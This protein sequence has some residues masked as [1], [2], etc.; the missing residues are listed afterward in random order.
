ML[1]PARLA[2]AAAGLTLRD[3]HDCYEWTFPL[4]RTH[5]GML[6]GNAV[7]GAM[8]WGRQN[9]LCITLNRGDFWD[10]RN[11]KAWSAQMSYANIR[12]LLERQD[13]SALREMFATPAKA[14]KPVQRPTLLPLG[15]LELHFEAGCTLH[16]GVLDIGKGE[17]EIIL[18]DDAGTEHAIHLT[19]QMNAPVMAARLPAALARP[20]LRRVTAH[21]VCGEQLAAVDVPQALPFDRDGS[22][23]WVQPRVEEP[24]ACLAYRWKGD[25]LWTTVVYGDAPETAIEAACNALSAGIA[26]GWAALLES[27]A[28]WWTAYWAD[29]P[30]LSIPNEKLSF[31]YNYGMYK[32]AGLTNPAG[33]PAGLQG[34]WI[35]EYQLPPWSGDYHFNINV[36]MCYWPAYAGNRLSHLAPLFR[37][38]ESWL[39]ILRQ[40]ALLFVGVEDG[41]VLPHAVDDRCAIMGGFWT[42]TIDHGCTAWVAKMLYDFWLYGGAGDDFLRAVAFPFMRGAM[43]VYEKMLDERDGTYVL[44]VSVSPEYR[45]AAMNAWGANASFQLAAVHWLLEKLHDAAARLDIT[46]EPQWAKIQRELPRATVQTVGRQERIALWEGTPQEESHRHH[47]HMAGIYPFDTLDIADARWGAIFQTTVNHWIQEGMG[48][49]SGWCMPWAAMLH[50]RAGNRDMAELTLEIWQRVFT[51]EGHGTLHDCEFPGLTLLGA[52]P[53]DR[54]KKEIMQMDAGMGATAAILDLMAHTRRGVLHLFPGCPDHWRDA[55]FDG[56]RIEG[57][58]RI[59]AARRGG[60]VKDLKVVPERDW[61]LKLQNPWPGAATVLRG[62]GVREPASGEVLEIR[63][64]AGETIAI[65]DANA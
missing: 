3:M 51:N 58:M 23:G 42:G 11:G 29:V 6:L 22:A 55:A 4:P 43:R 17:I 24:P 26:A 32:F 2:S 47:S 37:M 1:S 21:E 35:E 54:G 61:T 28:R 45:G 65:E 52:G 33:V 38:I 50:A 44:P 5:T 59:S 15:R 46:P 16:R 27:G 62:N 8:I 53:R 20:E 14:G 34:P 9:V 25:Q 18:A 12:R 48:M 30:R 64:N 40:N 7:L 63:V 13:E 19:M 56:I 57:A 60:V 39:P 10:H 49:W 41:L 36:Q 31:L